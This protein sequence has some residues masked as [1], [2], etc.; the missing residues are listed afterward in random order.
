MGGVKVANIKEIAV[1]GADAFVAGTA[2]F[3]AEDYKTRIDE[4]RAAI[5]I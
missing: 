5:K 2:I 3:Q 1:A 4:L